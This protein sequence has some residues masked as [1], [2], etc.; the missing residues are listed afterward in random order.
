MNCLIE[1]IVDK[2]GWVCGIADGRKG[3]PVPQQWMSYFNNRVARALT[4]LVCHY[5]CMWLYD[6]EEEFDFTG[7]NELQL[8]AMVAFN[9]Y[10]G[11]CMTSLG[12]GANI[13]FGHGGPGEFFSRKLSSSENEMVVEFETG[14]KAKIQFKPHFYHTFDLPVKTFGDL[15]SLNLP[16]PF[17]ENRYKSIKDNI[18]YLKD[19][20]EFVMCS[21]NGF[22]SGLHYFLCDY[23]EV[24]MGLIADHKLIEG[25]LDKLG[26]WNLAVAGQLADCGADCIALCD[27]LGA[28][29]SM[30]L[31]PDH[32]RKFFKKWH[33]QLCD[34]MHEKGVLVHLH[35]HGAISP[36]LN[37]I[38]D[39]GFDFVNPFDP[40]EGFDIEYLLKEY[41]KEFVI[42][43]GLPASFWLWDR[44][45]QLKN[46]EYLI[47]L[48]HEYGRFVL[49]DSGGIPEGVTKDDYDFITS[50]SRQL[51]GIEEVDYAV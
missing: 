25:M 4:P 28:K 9:N 23:Q 46:V 10:T 45:K 24:L 1:T 51:R 36:V 43:G 14:A 41:S 12:R 49:M 6:V 7:Y 40:E 33:K 31:S 32:Y 39:C 13:A 48:G 37:D 35:S 21:L 20:G 2:R 22:F 44:Q 50:K 38:A 16:D 34:N 27:D 19:R 3:L 30:L 17:D 15:K 11:R 8:N 18:K 42:V 5:D 47:K 26:N 29:Q